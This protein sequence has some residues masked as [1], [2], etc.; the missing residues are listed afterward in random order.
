MNT[1]NRARFTLVCVND[2]WFT[3]DREAN[4]EL[5][6]FSTRDGA[7]AGLRKLNATKWTRYEVLPINDR[8]G[9]FDKLERITAGTYDRKADATEKCA[10]MNATR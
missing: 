5:R 2:N 1:T 6:K 8:F 3:F 7:V 9:V 10:W 4:R